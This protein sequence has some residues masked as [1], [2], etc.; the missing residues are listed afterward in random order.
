VSVGND[1]LARGGAGGVEGDAGGGTDAGSSGLGA[2]AAGVGSGSR[3]GECF[4]KSGRGNA[5]E[6]GSSSKSVPGPYARAMAVRMSD[7]G[8]IMGRTGIFVRSETTR[9]TSS[10]VGSSMARN[11]VSTSRRSRRT[12]TG[13]TVYR[14][15]SSRSTKAS[16][17]GEKS[18]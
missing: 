7:G 8:A 14:S 1:G 15:A 6:T 3:L 12:Y 18:M 16:S 17:A 9:R 5:D 13:I 4:C 10:C 11:S 2:G